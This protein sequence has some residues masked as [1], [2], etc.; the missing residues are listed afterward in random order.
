MNCAPIEVISAA[1]A[2]RTSTSVTCAPSGPRRAQASSDARAAGLPS[3]TASTFPSGR[4]RTQPR[5]PQLRSPELDRTLT[6]DVLQ[7]R[8]QLGTIAHPVR[9]ASEA[10]IGG[11]VAAPGY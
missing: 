10:R 9:V 4:L 3:K 2:A 11:E 1:L 7:Q 6:H 5:A 8:N